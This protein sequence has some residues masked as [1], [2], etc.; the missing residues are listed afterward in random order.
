MKRKRVERGLYRQQNGTY[1]VYL[2]V[3]GRP[4]YKTVGVKLGEARR[5]RDLLASKAHT[6]QLPPA[7]QQL[8]A[9]RADVAERAG[10][11]HERERGLDR[12]PRPLD[13]RAGS[14]GAHV[15]R[16][17]EQGEQLPLGNLRSGEHPVAMSIRPCPLDTS[18]A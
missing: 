1:G 12:R 5:Q 9:L 4:R 11:E 15:Q 14:V 3:E 16:L 6:G 13:R 17:H 2:V 8:G 7:R 10:G 18:W